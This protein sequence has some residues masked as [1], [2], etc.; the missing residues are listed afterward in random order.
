MTDSAAA[1]GAGQERP[2]N[3]IPPSQAG[4]PAAG[5]SVNESPAST[6]ADAADGAQSFTVGP[7]QEASDATSRSGQGSARHQFLREAD[8]L[9]VGGDV[10]EGGVKNVL[11]LPGA[12]RPPPREVSHDHLELIRDA[13][14]SPPGFGDIE[15]TYSRASQTVILRGPEGCGK[16]ATAIRLLL[17]EGTGRIFR[18]DDSIKMSEIPDAI[19]T[20]ADGRHRIEEDAGFI[21]NQPADFAALRSSLL[22]RLEEP[23][24]VA[25]ARLIITV[26]TAALG[27][28]HELL[29][30]VVNQTSRPDLPDIVASHLRHLLGAAKA[31]SELARGEIAKL[32]AAVLSAD[33]SCGSAAGLAD[34]IVDELYLNPDAQNIDID[35]IRAR[36]SQRSSES[37]EIWF[38]AL[39][40]T[41]ST[42][43][44]IAL[45]VLNGLPYEVVV[46]GAKALYDAYDAEPE[47]L[48]ATAGDSLPETR[49]PFR[50]SRRALL[51]RLRAQSARVETYGPY[52]RAAADA[53]EYQNPRYCL[54]VIRHAWSNFQIQDALLRWLA[55]LVDD[56]TDPVRIFAGRALGVLA[57][58]SFDYL[59]DRVLV[60]WAASAQPHRR[61]AVA[62]ALRFVA[63]DSA[64]RPAVRRLVSG[65]YADR[66]R[67]AVQATAARAHGLALAA[68]D[69]V[70]ALE[71]LDRLSAVDDIRVIVS[72]GD[73]V[74]DLLGGAPDYVTAPEADSLALFALGKLG[75]ALG[76][77]DRTAMAQLIFLILADGLYTRVGRDA[78]SPF[79]EW[80]FM[81]RLGHRVPRARTALIELWRYVLND[82]RF[83]SE[84][85]RVLARWAA[86]AEGD[87]ELREAFL[88]L[89][90]AVTRGHERT[91][92]IVSR[93]ATGWTRPEN[94][95]PMPLVGQG[96]MTVLEAER[97]CND[98]R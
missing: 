12:R 62:Y 43:F 67:P 72:I 48:V 86:A 70:C 60:P 39:G 28:D 88:R 57:T 45:A 26:A 64:L 53:V 49:R 54:P 90:R 91:R 19:E 77:R 46:G 78:G 85:E 82:A 18:L 55:R 94:L 68:Y 84:S 4:E 71:A 7:G 3:A 27:S 89:V 23:L 93:Y 6:G 25:G 5:A 41:W 14:V 74:V 10:I 87:P 59:A 69:P 13:Y 80:P 22:E 1:P 38:A 8:R 83:P 40:D 31:E 32:I 11:N 16:L 96:L 24:S 92:V 81:L 9:L 66:D 15:G 36:V 20:D 58:L 56:G 2:G 47:V 37:F 75:E 33:S 42:T 29:G 50:L 17:G 98:R 63:A 73:A 65:W 97:G 30:Y 44:A 51:H 61:A 95:S 52:G 76:Q 35:R 34:A 21:L 79:V